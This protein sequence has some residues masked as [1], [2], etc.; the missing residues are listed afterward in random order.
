MIREWWTQSKLSTDDLERIHA[1]VPAVNSAGYDPWGL[2]LE[3]IKTGVASV[4]WL[5]RDYFRVATVG[6]E[7][8]PHGRAL[9]VAN[10]S[11]Q[12]PIDGLL[13]GLSLILDA[14]PPRVP[15]GMVER[16]VPSLPFVSTFLNRVGQVV[17]DSKNCIDLLNHEQT[18]LVFPEGTR[19][20]GKTY[21]KRYQLQRFGTGFVRIALET[22][23]PIIP[24][25]VIGCEE[26][27]PTVSE[28]RPLAKRLGVP[29]LP[30]SLSGP[31]PLPTKV[32]IRYGKP[33]LFDEAQTGGVPSGNVDA[34]VERVRA[35]LA[36]EIQEGL[37]ARAGRIFT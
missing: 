7:N 1:A 24:V 21:F 12:I 10:H 36:L 18:V 28:M 14:N 26:I 11:G 32:T 23:T 22:R 2:S 17:G 31:I 30:V 19:G 37:A 8:I 3:A 25:A 4:K 16:W 9:L 6:L 13:I 34:M 29:Y 5:Y 15:R 33:I 20:S 35:A 27:F